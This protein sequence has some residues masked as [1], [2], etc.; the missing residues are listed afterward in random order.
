M[1]MSPSPTCTTW[2]RGWNTEAQKRSLLHVAVGIGL[3][4]AGKSYTRAEQSADA[5][6]R[7]AEAVGIRRAQ[8]EISRTLTGHYGATTRTRP[9]RRGRESAPDRQ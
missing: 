2:Q 6:K 7:F 3:S 5:E 9:M 4:A 8:N 1:L